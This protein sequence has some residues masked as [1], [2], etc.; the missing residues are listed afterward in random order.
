MRCKLITEPATTMKA[1]ISGMRENEHPDE[2]DEEVPEGARP[3][4]EGRAHHHQRHGGP[5]QLALL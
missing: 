5:G 2:G 1:L 3:G 4:P